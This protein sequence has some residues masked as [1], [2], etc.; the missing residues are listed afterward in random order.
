MKL[1]LFT[2]LML[3]D[4]ILLLKNEKIIKL[5]EKNYLNLLPKINLMLNR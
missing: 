3:V 5:P 2:I 4:G 1:K